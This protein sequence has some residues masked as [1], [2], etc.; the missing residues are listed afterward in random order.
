MIGI[1]AAYAM[2]KTD[3]L[4]MT[5]TR[6]EMLHLQLH[7]NTLEIR[8]S[9]NIKAITGLRLLFPVAE[10]MMQYMMDF[11]QNR[12]HS[13]RHVLWPVKKHIHRTKKPHKKGPVWSI[14]MQQMELSGFITLM[15][16]LF[17]NTK[18]FQS[19]RKKKKSKIYNPKYFQFS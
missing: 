17:A 2:M 8:Q 19:T 14:S 13:K 18:S 1:F 16:E 7:A 10:K 3:G 9:Q 4:R 11:L 12:K 5:W 6:M 15:T